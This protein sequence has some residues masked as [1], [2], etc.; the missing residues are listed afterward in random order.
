MLYNFTLFHSIMCCLT[1]QLD[2][3][4]P[5]PITALS[6][7]PPSSSNPTIHTLDE[8]EFSPDSTLYVIDSAGWMYFLEPGAKSPSQRLRLHQPDSPYQ[9]S[10]SLNLP[11]LWLQNDPASL[12]FI[13]LTYLVHNYAQKIEKKCVNI[14]ILL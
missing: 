1:F 3:P 11:G 2:Q 4:S 14:S 6:F 12:S 5:C 10:N 8:N 9:E 13:D 7:A